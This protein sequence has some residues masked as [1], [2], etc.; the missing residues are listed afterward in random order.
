ME[1]LKMTGNISDYLNTAKKN[2]AIFRNILKDLK[3][4]REKRP[5]GFCIPEDLQIEASLE[6]ISQLY[7][8][9][10]RHGIFTIS[11]FEIEKDGDEVS[12]IISFQDIACL[13]GGGVSLRYAI[14]NNDVSYVR[15]ENI[16][17][18]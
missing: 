12:A 9:G 1:D 4:N 16:I 11:N 14:I 8:Q 5:M 15:A 17:M 6:K 13:S 3:S 7:S 10:N 18:S 2:E